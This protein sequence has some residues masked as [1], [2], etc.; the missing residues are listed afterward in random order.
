MQVSVL[1]RVVKS[2]IDIVSYAHKKK[3][4]HIERYRYLFMNLF[5]C[6]FIYLFRYLI[7]YLLI[8][9]AYLLPTS[10]QR[11]RRLSKPKHIA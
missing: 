1:V 7:M 2:E 4:A 11:G 5:I 10:P 8:Q 9:N 6:R 3:Y